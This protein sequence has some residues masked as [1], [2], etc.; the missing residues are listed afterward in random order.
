MLW[1]A[2]EPP[3]PGKVDAIIVPTTRP[4]VWL[5]EAATAAFSLGC[6]LVTLHSKK[7]T[8][9][10]AATAYLGG[11]VDLI[12]I[13]LPDP[14]RLRLPELETSRVLADTMFEQRSDVS[15]KR[16]LA[17]V[18]SHMLGWER[19]VFLDDDI[20]V[21]DPADLSRA[22]GLLDT[23]TAVGLGIGGFPRQFGRM[24]R[25]PR[26]RRQ[27]GHLHRRWCPGR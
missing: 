22:V 8:S 2:D 9:A 14:A 17:V 12:A 11:S 23:H 1:A 5:K 26:G 16:N 4:V 3:Q 13:D 21:P 15:T 24:P 19:V 18:L 20:Q 7:W 10:H 6:P 27:A 25:L